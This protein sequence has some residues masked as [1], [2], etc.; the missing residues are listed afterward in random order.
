MGRE[1]GVMVMPASGRDNV[2][3]YEGLDN[4]CMGERLE[5]HGERGAVVK[6]LHEWRAIMQRE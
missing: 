3:V 2:A 4:S 6:G 1:V 5:P